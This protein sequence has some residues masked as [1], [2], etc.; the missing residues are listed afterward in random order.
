MSN[1]FFKN[2]GPFYVS[3]I[4][5]LLDIKINEI[6]KDS[7]LND[8]KDLYSSN[9]LDITFF[10]SKKYKEVAKNTKASFCITTNS[11][12]KDLP[13]SCTPLIVQ[14]VKNLEFQH[15]NDLVLDIDHK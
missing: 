5:K 13:S 3:E 12:K 8:I 2:H 6:N 15:V 11:L 1:P 4:L 10:H 7:E 14:N 9:N